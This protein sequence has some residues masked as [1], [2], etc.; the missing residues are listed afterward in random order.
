M[1]QSVC[2]TD[3]AGELVEERCTFDSA[4]EKHVTAVLEPATSAYVIQ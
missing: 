2:G 1:I 4:I 3:P